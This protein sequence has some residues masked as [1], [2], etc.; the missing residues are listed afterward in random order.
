MN[1]LDH[2]RTDLER[3][4][5]DASRTLRLV[6]TFVPSLETMLIDWGE[7]VDIHHKITSPATKQRV[8]FTPW[9]TPSKSLILHKEHGESITFRD[10]LIKNT[11][12]LPSAIAW[13]ELFTGMTPFADALQGNTHAS[14]VIIPMSP[15]F[16]LRNRPEMMADVWT[17]YSGLNIGY[18]TDEVLPRLTTR[19][20]QHIHTHGT[21]EA[22]ATSLLTRTAALSDE[23]ASQRNAI[24]NQLERVFIEHGHGTYLHEGNLTVEF[25]DRHY[26]DNALANGLSINTMPFDSS[27]ISFSPEGYFRGDPV[28]PI[29]RLIDFSEAR[30]YNPKVEEGLA[31]GSINPSVDTLVRLLSGNKVYEKALAGS[32]IFHL[33]DKLPWTDQLVSLVKSHFVSPWWE[34]GSLSLLKDPKLKWDTRTDIRDK[35]VQ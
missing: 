8:R 29:V 30:Y 5:L 35:L 7:R 9:K 12:S 23:I 33:R 16:R 6:K 11:N 21:D 3:R 19:L 14:A 34:S 26:V 22:E 15:V 13:Q 25:A 31:N 17:R 24:R 28:V 20:R 32:A 1:E 2:Y 4:S 18:Y 10:G 27:S